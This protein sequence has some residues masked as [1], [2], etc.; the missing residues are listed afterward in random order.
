PNAGATDSCVTGVSGTCQLFTGPTALT[1]NTAGTDT[2][3]ALLDT[4]F[5]GDFPPDAD[6]DGEP[7]ATATITWVAGAVHS[8]L[9]EPG[10]E[11]TGSR[12]PN[13]DSQT[14]TN[15]P[16]STGGGSTSSNS[17]GADIVYAVVTA[18][19]GITS[20]GA[21]VDWGASTLTVTPNYTQADV[22]KTVGD[23]STYTVVSKNGL[24]VANTNCTSADIYE[25][26]T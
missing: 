24:G 11:F 10:G 21:E 23:N 9:L 26:W 5:D 12:N 7:S 19:S 25:N 22:A 13:G 18:I 2:V 14:R 6:A 8:L 17:E 1:S 15:Y 3:T 4:D 16:P 20:D